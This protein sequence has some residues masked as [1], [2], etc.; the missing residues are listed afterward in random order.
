M[1]AFLFSRA[2]SALLRE[3]APGWFW[4]AVAALIVLLMLPSML[5][6]AWVDW[7]MRVS[8]WMVLVLLAG[9][10]C[11]LVAGVGLVNL[12]M[13][14]LRRVVRWQTGVDVPHGSGVQ[15]HAPHAA[16]GACGCC[17]VLQRDAAW[18]AG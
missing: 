10:C 9:L 6:L 11:S 14:L 4:T 5:Y 15:G 3:T 1:R 12:V 2:A 18:T 17:A 8:G 16:A 13:P 7:F